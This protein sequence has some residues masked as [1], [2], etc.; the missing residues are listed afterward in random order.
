VTRRKNDDGEE[1]YQEEEVD[2]THEL[3]YDIPEPDYTIYEDEE[4]IVTEDPPADIPI[5]LIKLGQK[6]K[7]AQGIPLKKPSA[8]GRPKK[9]TQ[10]ITPSDI[11][12]INDILYPEE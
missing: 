11:A 1:V 9:K 12:A 10:N 4:Q 6:I 8:R 3:D 7:R 5:D 2:V